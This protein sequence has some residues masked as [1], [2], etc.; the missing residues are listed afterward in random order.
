MTKHRSLRLK[1]SDMQDLLLSDRSLIT[2]NSS[3][4]LKK[5]SVHV[6]DDEPNA[7]SLVGGGTKS[8]EK[9]VQIVG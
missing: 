3:I 8:K 1:I 6:R 2:D 9:A 4:G 7:S 5:P